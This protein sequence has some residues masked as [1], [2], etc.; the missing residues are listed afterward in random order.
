MAEDPNSPLNKALSGLGTTIQSITGKVEAGKTRV[1]EYKSQIITKLKEVVQQLNYLKEN[2][3]LKDLPQL[4]KQLQNSQAALQQKTE[5]LNQTKTNLDEANRNLEELR[6]NLDSINRQLA[7]KDKQIADL[8]TSGNQKDKEIQELDAQF[9]ELDKEK[10][11]IERKLES[12]QQQTNS[13]VERIGQIN[14]TLANQIEL[15]DTIV[16]EL[17][18]LDSNTDDVAVQFKAV[19]DNINAIINMINNPSQGGAQTRPQQ[20]L[21]DY[22]VELNFNNLLNLHN[23]SPSGQYLQYMRKVDKTIRDG[24]QIKNDIDKLITKVEEGTS[25]EE[26]EYA[27]NEIK[28][29]LTTNQLKVDPYNTMGGKRRRKTMKKIHRRTRKKMRGG[30]IYS[31]SKELDKASSVVSSSSTSKSSSGS[32]SKSKSKKRRYTL[33]S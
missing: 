33:R 23:E 4:R 27:I 15:I 26:K 12:A 5:E 16:S 8:T 20:Q 28:R 11:E 1:R 25:P 24:G 22:D 17:G 6:Q 10:T 31:S 30:Y 2:S 7:E 19:G 32:K 13:L 9:R 21:T 14:A 29:I 3:N 18:N